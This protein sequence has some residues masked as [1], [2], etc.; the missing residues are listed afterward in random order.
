MVE[1]SEVADGAELEFCLMISQ[2]EDEIIRVQ[3]AQ[4]GS[5]AIFSAADSF[6]QTR[7]LSSNFKNLVALTFVGKWDT[8]HGDSSQIS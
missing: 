7:P 4:I 3:N 2:L 5:S 1:G 6:F 8:F